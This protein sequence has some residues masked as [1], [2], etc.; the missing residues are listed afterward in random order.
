[1]PKPKRKRLLLKRGGLNMARFEKQDFLP[2]LTEVSKCG[3][4]L[5]KL[6]DQ[7]DN[8]RLLCEMDC[9]VQSKNILP[10]MAKI[11]KSFSDLQHDLVD[12]LITESFHKLEQKA[13]PKAQVAVDILI[14]NLYERTADIG[15][16]ATDGDV[17]RFAAKREHTDQGRKKIRER[18]REYTAKYTVYNEVIIL[19]KDFTVLANLDGENHILGQKIDDPLLEETIHTDRTF[20]ETFRPSPL[21][22]RRKRAHIFSCKICDENSG[23]AVGVICLC[24]RFMNETDAIFQ[25]LASSNDGYIVSVIDGNNVVLASSDPYQLPEGIKVEPVSDGENRIVNYRGQEYYAKTLPS[26]GYQGYLGLGWKGHVMV[27]LNLAF[28]GKTADILEK[29][30]PAI[31]A[32][33]MKQARSF[34][35]ALQKIISQ[36]QKINRS[37]KS[38]VFN[39]QIVTRE[40]SEDQE[41]T[42]LRPLLNYISK[43]GSGIGQIFD[44][45]VQNLF[46]TVISSNMRNSA[47]LAMLAVDIMD[48]N[49]YERSDDCRWWALNPSFRAVLAQ[50]GITDCDRKKLTD[51]LSYINSL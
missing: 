25:K 31:M 13:I 33:L 11:Q 47:F 12:A 23:E 37:L 42:R 4:E 29:I 3:S 51:I 6:N 30:D 50:D 17:R 27:P 38:I 22:T 24:F 48:R 19:D 5:S 2:Y 46:A 16:L 49:L 21:Q 7:W 14:R 26:G 28:K 39:G 44:S 41:F 20:L 35:S 34:S 15:F 9:P 36:T 10:E 18:L 40:N 45:S 43:M 8:V 1:M 32:G